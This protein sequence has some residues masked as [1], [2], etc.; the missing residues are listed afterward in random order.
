MAGFGD[1]ALTVAILSSAKKKVVT[2]IHESYVDEW[3][4]EKCAKMLLQVSDCK[5]CGSVLS[6][7]GQSLADGAVSE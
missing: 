6:C 3:Q 1:R 2:G 7:C 5:E 4:R